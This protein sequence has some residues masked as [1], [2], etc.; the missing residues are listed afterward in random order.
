MRSFRQRPVFCQRWVW[1]FLHDAGFLCNANTRTS[2]ESNVNVN[3]RTTA[4]HTSTNAI[5]HDHVYKESHTSTTHA[6]HYACCRG[7]NAD[8]NSDVTEPNEGN[9]DTNPD[10]SFPNTSIPRPITRTGGKECENT[11]C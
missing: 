6:Y 4:S 7:D 10:P 1:K 11:H 9:R 5:D 2:L 3:T 8:A